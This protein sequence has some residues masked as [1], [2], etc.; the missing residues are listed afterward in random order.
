MITVHHSL[1]AEELE[2]K[3]IVTF[4]N[5]S[6][7]REHLI[8]KIPHQAF[9]FPSHQL[10][11]KLLQECVREG[12]PTDP[13]FINSVLG[14]KIEST[15]LNW[16]LSVGI[17]SYGL[18]FR[19]TEWAIDEL[20]RLYFNRVSYAVSDKI[21]KH[22]MTGDHAKIVTLSNTLGGF[23]SRLFEQKDNN[24][25]DKAV[26]LANSNDEYIKA[27]YPN[28]SDLIGGFTRKDLSAIG[29]KSGHNKTTFALS[30]GTSL[31]KSAGINKLLYISADEA[32]EQ[33]A[34]RIIAND[35]RIKTSDMR[36][37][38]IQ[39]DPAE[40]NKAVTTVYKNKLLILDDVNK[41]V[42]IATAIMDYKPDMTIIDHLQELDYEE[43]GGLS[44]SAVT[45]GLTR[46]KLANRLVRGNLF[47]LSQVRDK[48][49]DE[50]ID[51]KMPRPHDFLYA[52][53]IRRKAREL[54]VCYWR[55][56][57]TYAK[58][59]KPIFELAIYKSTYSETATVRFQYNPEYAEF[60]PLANPEP[61]QKR[62]EDM[63]R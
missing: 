60:T 58:D 51:D 15:T 19:G 44:D 12:K 49:I 50:R 6:V 14:T 45:R 34:R 30:I 53:D 3:V 22:A 17:D 39:L 8:K 16:F 11:I 40:V 9:Y 4:L 59:D 57:D 63:W 23:R 46:M 20:K 27:P 13:V 32:G 5:V 21:S 26:V 29:G 56:K 25:F 52:S 37:K 62:Q 35:M 1:I 41:P 33:V 24:V 10:L 54:M 2:K 55:Y 36:Q 7:T 31:I 61:Q 48:L 42:D 43:Y 18:T 38:R 28:I 47:I